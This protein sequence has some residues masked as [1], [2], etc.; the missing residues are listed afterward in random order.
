MKTINISKY[1]KSV[2]K[3]EKKNISKY[4]FF[5]HVQNSIKYTYNW[6]GTLESYLD[7]IKD[8]DRGE[9]LEFYELSG[10]PTAQDFKDIFDEEPSVALGF[11]GTGNNYE[12]VVTESFV[13]DGK[14]KPT[15][16]THSQKEEKYE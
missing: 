16:P 12:W 9:L 5:I 10:L 15:N 2:K 6:V 8:K 4:F 13:V 3:Y 1:N 11:Q 7:F 14:P